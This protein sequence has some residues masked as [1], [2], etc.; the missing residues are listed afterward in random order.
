MPACRVFESLSM[1]YEKPAISRISV[2][3]RAMA[4]ILMAERRGRCT[5]LEM[6]RRFMK[7]VERVYCKTGCRLSAIKSLGRQPTALL[8]LPA[9]RFHCRLAQL[10]D[11]RPWGLRQRELL[12]GQNGIQLQ[13]H[14]V[15]HNVIFFARAPDLN[16][17]G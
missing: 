4:K 14:H 13:F 12:V 2:T 11:L 15:Q 7:A 6:T 3:S 17:R 1:P 10:F 5:R 9:R 16:L 8:R